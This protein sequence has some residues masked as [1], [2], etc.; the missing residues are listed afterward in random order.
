M[1][2]RRLSLFH[3]NSIA[4]S[5]DLN[6]AFLLPLFR[7]ST[8]PHLS[9]IDLD[10]ILWECS[11]I[12]P[13]FLAQLPARDTPLR[14][15]ILRQTELPPREG[16]RNKKKPSYRIWQ[17]LIKLLRPETLVV[18]HQSLAWV[19]TVTGIG[20]WG[21]KGLRPNPTR[22]RAALDVSD[23]QLLKYVIPEV[24]A[25]YGREKLPSR[26]ELFDVA[27]S[28]Y[29]SLEQVGIEVVANFAPEIKDYNLYSREWALPQRLEDTKAR[30]LILQDPIP[31]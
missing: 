24:I 9:C 2:E 5:G 19:N 22:E 18:S 27:P 3:V 30:R 15:L 12:R 23:G 28:I 10:D 1:L 17:P 13:T 20:A 26:V 8:G 31:G 21:I 16:R 7:C 4:L 14:T 6:D 11:I 25:L 29:Q